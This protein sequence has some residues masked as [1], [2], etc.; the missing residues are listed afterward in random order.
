M[1]TYEDQTNMLLLLS[2]CHQANV[3]VR[4]AKGVENRVRRMRMEIQRKSRKTPT[5]PLNPVALLPSSEHPITDSNAHKACAFA[6]VQRPRITIG[7][8]VVDLRTCTAADPNMQWRWSACQVLRLGVGLDILVLILFSLQ[9]A[10][11]IINILRAIPKSSKKN[12]CRH[13]HE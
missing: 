2:A 8:E 6:C 7:I 5:C 12:Q 4:D 13:H 10:R 11:P 9:I 3:H 1:T